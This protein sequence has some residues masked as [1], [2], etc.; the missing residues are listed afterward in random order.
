MNGFYWTHNHG[1]LVWFRL[2]SLFPWVMF[3]HPA[4]SSGV[5][6][7]I[8]QDSWEWYNIC[9]NYS[10]LTR[11]HNRIETTLTFWIKGMMW[12]DI[13]IMYLCLCL[14]DVFMLNQLVA[15]STTITTESFNTWNDGQTCN[16]GNSRV[17]IQQWLAFF[18]GLASF[19]QLGFIG[20]Q[21]HFF[22]RSN[23]RDGGDFAAVFTR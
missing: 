12:D 13:I 23:F 3:K 11:R 18:W 1:G 2:S 7:L 5:Y 6:I 15:H 22:G 19:N 9:P 21:G 10:D 14:I 20:F 16:L 4:K 17:V 8:L